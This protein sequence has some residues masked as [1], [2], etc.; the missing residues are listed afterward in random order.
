MD[1]DI[2]KE[3]DGCV[4]ERQPRFKDWDWIIRGASLEP[5]NPYSEL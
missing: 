4:C 3:V 1:N 2:K 5:Q